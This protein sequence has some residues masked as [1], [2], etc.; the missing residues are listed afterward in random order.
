[1]ANM[2][3]NYGLD[4]LS[5]SEESLSGLI[6]FITKDAKLF[7]GYYGAPYVYK[8]AEDVEFWLSTKI[9]CDK[10]LEIDNFNTHCGNPCVCDL[11]FYQRR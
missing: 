10:N 2:L 9:I 8:R 4:I 11:S 7:Q 3:E 1:M 6:G 5:D